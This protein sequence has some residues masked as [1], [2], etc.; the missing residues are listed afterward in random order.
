MT[1][2]EELLKQAVDSGASDLHI[3][4]TLSPRLRINGVLDEI[5]NG[6]ALSAKE[7]LAMLE[8]CME[9]HAKKQLV[10]N[11]DADFA[12]EIK[13]LGRFRVNIFYEVKGVAASFRVIP[14]KIPTLE[15]LHMPAILK[16]FTKLPHGLVLITGPTGCGK[17]TTLAAM[18]DIINHER[19]ANI[20]T[21]EDPIEFIYHS[22]K[23]LI[24]QRELDKTTISF[25]HAL[26]SALREDPDILLVGEMRD[27]DT[28]R[29]ALT[30][31]ETGHLVFATLHTASAPESIHRIIDVF[32]G[33]EKAIV[34]SML[35]E[36]L[37]AIVAQRLMPK[38][39]GGRVAALEIMIA[40]SAIRNLIREDQIPQMKSV[41]QTSS[42]LGMQ[43][44]E[45]HLKELKRQNL[46]EALE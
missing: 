37:Q 22:D 40:N 29:L 7:T 4:S 19:K 13:N 17:S 16:E 36:S 1:S 8:N 32:P 44:F 27:L 35:S 18:I 23:S 6:T 25:S 45:Q 34:R 46:I 14:E 42:A 26:R 31:A 43:T 2:I 10:E 5:P 39:G 21:I 38:K 24:N 30:A 9:A 20:I 3:A 41:I 33:D 28:V 15:S 11:M 12:L